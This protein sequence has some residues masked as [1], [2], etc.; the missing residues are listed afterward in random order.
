MDKGGLNQLFRLKLKSQKEPYHRLQQAGKLGQFHNVV[1][2][3]LHLRQSLETETRPGW[4][5]VKILRLAT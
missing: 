1:V 4:M 3:A 2:E 5:P